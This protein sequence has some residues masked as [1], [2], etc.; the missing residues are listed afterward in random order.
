MTHDVMALVITLV[1]TLV[2]M[3]TTWLQPGAR[4][5]DIQVQQ[6]HDDACKRLLRS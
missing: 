2:M 3:L 1:M 4:R 5:H 6:V